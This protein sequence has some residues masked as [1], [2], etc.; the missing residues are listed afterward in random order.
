VLN[1]ITTVLELAAAAL[2]VAAASFAAHAVTPQPYSLAAALGVAGIGLL[3]VS[4]VIA[5][6]R[7]RRKPVA[8]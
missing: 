1:L 5:P 4:F 6:L 2:I 8:R 7:T 3:V